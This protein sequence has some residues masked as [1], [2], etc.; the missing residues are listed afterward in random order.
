MEYKIPSINEMA[1]EANETT[2][3]KIEK[4]VME[5]NIIGAQRLYFEKISNERKELIKL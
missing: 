5:G 2:E 3:K 4:L 1:R